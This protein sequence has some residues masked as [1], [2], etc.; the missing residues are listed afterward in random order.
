MPGPGNKIS[1]PSCAA[2]A[3]FLPYHPTHWN[4]LAQES[5]MRRIALSLVLAL[6]IIPAAVYGASGDR[7][8][9]FGVN[10]VA[11]AAPGSPEPVSTIAIQA[12]NKV[13]TGGQCP[14][15]G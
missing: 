6:G 7:D 3:T 4:P 15:R 8:R 11:Y 12:D 5:D 1:L 2:F 10:G 13:I 14:G 9:S